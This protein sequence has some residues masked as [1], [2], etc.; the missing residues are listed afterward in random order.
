MR[1][2]FKPQRTVDRLIN[3]GNR[4]NRSHV[5]NC[6]EFGERPTTFLC[7]LQILLWITANKRLRYGDVAGVFQIAQM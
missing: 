3:V 1:R 5:Q 2:L 6:F 7:C 4:H